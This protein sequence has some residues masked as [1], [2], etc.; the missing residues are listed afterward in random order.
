MAGSPHSTALANDDL[1]VGVGGN[2]NALGTHSVA[3]A[4]TD[5]S[6]GAGMAVGFGA[7]LAAAQG[8][9]VSVPHSTTAAY[10]LGGD[11]ND[12]TTSTQFSNFSIDFPH[13]QA[14][15]S[16]SASMVFVGI[17]SSELLPT[18]PSMH[19]SFSSVGNISHYAVA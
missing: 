12:A 13:G 10:A 19:D 7:F 5:T 6:A 15:V 2:A 11:T 14:P 1:F 17:Q 3:S 9:A 4:V 18:I 8:T 16:L